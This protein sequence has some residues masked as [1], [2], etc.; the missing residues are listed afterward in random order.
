MSF[1]GEH[2]RSTAKLYLV[3]GPIPKSVFNMEMENS[4]V[5]WEIPKMAHLYFVSSTVNCFM[6]LCVNVDYN[7]KSATYNRINIQ[8]L[9]SAF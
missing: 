9:I 1:D 2:T 4:Q 8:N 3:Q 7:Q 5:F 6:S